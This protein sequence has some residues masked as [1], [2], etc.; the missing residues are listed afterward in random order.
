MTIDKKT[1]AKVAHL[2][3]IRLSEGELEK[4]SERLNRI[5]GWIEQLQKVNTDNVKE[6]TGVGDSG[7]RM[8]RDRVKDGNKKDDVLAN[9]PEKSFDC[10]VVP[11]VIE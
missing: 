4:S 2:A 1:V 6:M 11:K 9:A 7:L 3:R 5:F 10:Y 8:R